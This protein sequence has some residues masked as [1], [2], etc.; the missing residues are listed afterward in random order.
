MDTEEASLREN[1]SRA[2]LQ[3]QA[4]K[5]GRMEQTE[6]KTMIRHA[7]LSNQVPRFTVYSPIGTGPS[8]HYAYT[9]AYWSFINHKQQ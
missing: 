1:V 9:N 6:R 4:Q 3:E 5:H 8:R 2:G 7:R